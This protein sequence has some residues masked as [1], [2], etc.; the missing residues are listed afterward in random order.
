M[1]PP[2]RDAAHRQALWRAA[3]D[4]VID[5]VDSDHA[6]HTLAEKARRHPDS[7]SGVPGVQNLLPLLL[8]HHAAGRL[9]LARLID[10]TSAGPARIYGIAA[11]GR[12][13]VGLD[14]DLT[15]V[16][17]KARHT[18]T[19][20][21]IASKCAWTPFDGLEVTGWPVATMIRGHVVMRD[22]EALG[23]P[24]GRPVRFLECL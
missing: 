14:A 16:D 9:T 3:R 6:P 13:A 5:V 11:K 2:I 24:V 22:G 23:A 8:D 4:G 20:D 19:A 1:N 12:L 21:W 17:L 18:I 10:L 15:L 7:P